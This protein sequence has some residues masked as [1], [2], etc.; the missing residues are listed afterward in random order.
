[1]ADDE[2]DSAPS[3]SESTDYQTQF[4]PKENDDEELW[5]VI[6]ILEE[7]GRKYKVR[8]AGIDPKTKK[9]WDPTWVYKYDCTDKLIREWKKKKKAKKKE[10]EER[11]KSK[12]RASTASSKKAKRSTSTSTTTTT[13]QT[14]RLTKDSAQSTTTSTRPTSHIETPQASSSRVTLQDSKPPKRSRNVRESPI[15]DAVEP[16]AGPSRP[17]KKRKVEVEV[18]VPSSS[19]SETDEEELL[20][21][22]FLKKLKS[23]QSRSGSNALSLSPTSRLFLVQEE[24]ENTQEAEGLFPSSPPRPA[25]PSPPQANRRRPS[26]SSLS[27]AQQIPQAGPSKVGRKLV[28]QGR[29]SANDTFSREGIV[30]ETQASAAPASLQPRQSASPQDAELIMDSTV[31]STPPRSGQPSVSGRPSSVKG[32]MRPN[33]SKQLRPIPVVTPSVFRPHLPS[34][35]I[36]EIEEFSSPERDRRK[37]ARLDILTQES[38]ELAQFTQ[39]QVD[40]FVDWDGGTPLEEDMPAEVDPFVEDDEQPEPSLGPQLDSPHANNDRRQAMKSILDKPAAARQQPPAEAGISPEIPLMPDLPSTS[41]SARADVDSQSQEVLSSQIEELHAALEEKEQQVTQL[42]LQIQELQTQLSTVENEKAVEAAKFEAELQALREGSDEKSE[43]ISQLESQLVELQLQFTHVA[44]EQ[45]QQREQHQAEVQGLQESLEERNEQVAQLESALVELQTEIAAITEENEKLTEAQQHSADEHAEQLAAAH[46]RAASLESE[47]ADIRAQLSKAE[48][49]SVALSA[50]LESSTQDWERR[51]KD[52]ESD[53]DLYK[54]LY[55]E[56]STHASR[57]AAENATLEERARVAEGQTKDGLAL[58]RGT[59]EAQM[60]KLRE[61]AEKWRAQCELLMAKDKATD[62]DVRRRAALERELRAEN[63][64]RVREENE[65]RLRA[66][67]ARRLHAETDDWRR[68]V[69]KMEGLFAQMEDRRVHAETSNGHEDEDADGD[70]DMDST[71]PHAQANGSMPNTT[72]PG[73][74]SPSSSPNGVDESERILYVCQHVHGTEMCNSTFASPQAVME[75]AWKTHYA[76]LE[77]H[78]A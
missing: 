12:A 62:D 55:S 50:R 76:G 40:S 27:S 31:P 29:P 8:W 69:Q 26:K 35:D 1:M 71:P 77:P 18:V 61:E 9:P 45:D 58:I 68:Q 19:S 52:L 38:I 16:A 25:T 23:T 49:E 20:N 33:R 43:Q 36:D 24:E 13:R 17:R 21:P 64:E 47:L 6:E 72:W 63:E 75:H 59:F 28:L 30:P 56:A 74:A 51:Y 46:Q 5:D 70:V 22:H 32:K 39:D 57:L 65:E 67:Y 73:I 53:R 37:E 42:E 44:S 14:R 15:E 34:M 7:K 66:E 11:R 78:A 60:H 54:N 10:A 48:E 41:T 2:F 4:I 3:E